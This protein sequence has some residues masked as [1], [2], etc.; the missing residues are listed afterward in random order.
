[1]GSV[2]WAWPYLARSSGEAGKSVTLAA[3]RHFG[4]SWILR[5]GWPSHA[6][7]FVVLLVF[8]YLSGP[9][10]GIVEAREVYKKL[11]EARG[12]WAL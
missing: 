3:P 2:A 8:G 12:L 4:N 9:K 1:M 7:L 11:P 10:N 6:F 5:N